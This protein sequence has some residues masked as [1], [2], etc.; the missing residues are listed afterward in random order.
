VK[1]DVAVPGT[2]MTELD[3]IAVGLGGVE[4][5]VADEGDDTPT[6]VATNTSGTAIVQRN[7]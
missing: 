5:G 7:P 1:V 4:T 3:E 6:V 2:P